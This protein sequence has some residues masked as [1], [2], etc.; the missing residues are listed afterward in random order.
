MVYS[1]T[2]DESPKLTLAPIT[3]IEEIVQNVSMI[4]TTMKN[5]VPLF[6]DFGVS[7]TFLDRPTVAAEAVLIADIIDAIEIYEPRAKVIN[8]SFVRN[9]MTGVLIP[10]LELGINE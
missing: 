3:L 2:V 5:T 4:V 7:A 6:R 10:N 1:F 8:V 9:D